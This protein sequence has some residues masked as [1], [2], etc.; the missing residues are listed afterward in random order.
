MGDIAFIQAAVLGMVV[1]LAVVTVDEV[2][3]RR[4]KRRNPERCCTGR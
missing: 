3:I 4:R 1:V 2:S